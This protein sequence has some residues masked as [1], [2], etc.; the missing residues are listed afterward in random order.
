MFVFTACMLC[1]M[2]VRYIPIQSGTHLCRS[3]KLVS[4]IDCLYVQLLVMIPT[5]NTMYWTK[6]IKLNF[7][8]RKVLIFYYRRISKTVVVLFNFLKIFV[9]TYGLCIHWV[10]QI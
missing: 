3:R 6:F 4:L 2:D 5:F 9:F 8:L 1:F 10:C 7:I